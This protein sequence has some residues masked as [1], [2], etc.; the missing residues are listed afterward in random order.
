MKK[1]L[2]T[3]YAVNPYKGSEDGMGWN[4]ILQIAKLNYVVAVTRKNNRTSIERYFDEHDEL[5]ELKQRI[6]F[7]YFDWPQQLLWWKKGSL[8]S[9]IYFYFWQL[10]CA[11]WLRRR[12]LNV[13]IVHNL[14]FHNDWTPSFLWL[15][16]KP[17]VWGPV[18][19]HPKIPKQFILPVYGYKAYLKDRLLWVSKEFF[20]TV[21]PFLFIT[22][23]MAAHII[24]MNSD[25][26][27]HLHPP[28]K[29]YSIIPSVAVEPPVL[30]NDKQ[31]EFF[32]V[33]S[34]GRIEP[35][36]GFDI[37]VKSF[38]RFYH[39][40][41]KEQQL[42][43]RLT[44]VGSGSQLDNI[45]QL[46]RRENIEQCTQIIEWQPREEVKR[47][48]Q[49]ASVFMFPSHEGAGM[50]VA[51]AMSYKLPVICWDNSGP[52]EFIH[53]S[54][55]LSIPYQSYQVS[56]NRFAKRI[57]LL[58]EDKMLYQKESTMAYGRYNDYLK[59]EL[60]SKQ[61]NEIYSTCYKQEVAPGTIHTR[62]S[63]T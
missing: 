22:R 45:K 37:T 49:N 41:A 40:L 8:L 56:V 20:W 3:A 59:W 54:S 48:Y 25:V 39:Q 51:E 44:L 26:A 28:S 23:K 47:L 4:F 31:Q 21:D 5:N 11:V 63:L 32:N 61:L 9:M 19:H 36:K 38:A 10:S 27:C 24:C 14:N 50:V 6:T 30:N 12:K 43:V 18:G 2:V 34:V 7:L 17:F 13:D 58:F 53:P 16:N 46:V 29:K 55:M 15:L 33:L 42:K 35:L 52:G 57:Q 1:I 60:R 62:Q